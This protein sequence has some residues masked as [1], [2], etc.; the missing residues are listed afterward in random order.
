MIEIVKDTSLIKVKAALAVGC[1][2]QPHEVKNKR[3]VY[4]PFRSKAELIGGLFQLEAECQRHYGLK[5]PS[6]ELAP[7]AGAFL[8]FFA[9]PIDYSR[10]V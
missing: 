4:M 8:G 3:T 9:V 5:P 10:I 6:R 2:S 7:G 1:F